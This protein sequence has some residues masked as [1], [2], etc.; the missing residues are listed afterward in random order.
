M[1]HEQSDYIKL[2]LADALIQLLDERGYGNFGVSDVCELAGVGRT[3][4]YRHVGCKNGMCELL[5]FKLEYEWARYC[6]DRGI[7]C[8]E[9]V[10]T[11]LDFFYA[12]R[13]LLQ[14]IDS[15]GLLQTLMSAFER[16]NAHCLASAQEGG[17]LANFFVYGT[18]GVVLQWIRRGFDETPDQVRAH[19]DDAMRRAALEA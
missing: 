9:G 2:C 8:A 11:L 15:C 6:Q 5:V 12:N 7:S 10:W 14:L 1:K 18:F 16:M 3:T 17:Y 4:F 19:I 13:K